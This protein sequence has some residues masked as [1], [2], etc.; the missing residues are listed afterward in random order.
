MGVLVT[1]SPLTPSPFGAWAWT[2]FVT[3]GMAAAAA[4][5]ARRTGWWRRAEP[6]PLR[7]AGVRPAPWALAAA[8]LV[9]LAFLPSLMWL[10]TRWTQSVWQNA[11]GLFVPIAMFWL[12]RGSL[13]E[14]PVERFEASAWCA[15]V[16]GGALALLALGTLRASPTL[17]ACGLVVALPGLVL[18]L[19]GREGLRRLWLPLSLAPFGLPVDYDSAAHELL[20]SLSAA[21][22]EAVLVG[23]RIHVARVDSMLQLSHGGFEITEA[24]SGFSTLYGSLAFALVIAQLVTSPARR[25][26]VLVAAAPVAFAANLARILAL[27]A[28]AAVWPG[29]LETPLHKGTGVVTFLLAFLALAALSGLLRPRRRAPD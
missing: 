23:L 19:L 20:R 18:L 24:C 27:I 17:A 29:F 6:R 26:L 21:A 12:G 10:V 4:F 22:T 5:A 28:I 11:H 15:P 1:F 7:R 13:R 3:G 25:A 16:L 2:S 14:R 8:A 9:A